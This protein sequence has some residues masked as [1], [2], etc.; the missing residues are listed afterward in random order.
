[1]L[2]QIEKQ[3]K[4]SDEVLSNLPMNNVKN[5]ADFKREVDLEINNYEKKA[6][7]ILEELKR[8]T[9]EYEKLSYEEIFSF[10]EVLGKLKKALKYTNNLSTS[11]EKLNF[12]K[13]VYQLT[14]YSEEDLIANNKNILKAINT[15]R[16]ADVQITNKDF[17]YTNFVSD[18][19]QIFFEGNLTTL[20]IKNTFDKIYWQCP[21][22]KSVV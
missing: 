21:D 14:H 1:M 5:A 7:E 12:D 3:I 22:R 9:S 17:N 4:L 15:F 13:I 16:A 11:Y 6:A 10:D 19:M 8:R 20:K 18:Y 2:E